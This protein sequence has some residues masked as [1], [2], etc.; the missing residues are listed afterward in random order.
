[1]TTEPLYVVIDNCLE[2]ES[3]PMPRADAGRIATEKTIAA[4]KAGEPV[5][6]GGLDRFT[7]RRSFKKVETFAV[8]VTATE[9]AALRSAVCKGAKIKA[10]P[11]MFALCEIIDSA[12]KVGPTYS[13]LEAEAALCIW[14]DMLDRRDTFYKEAF[15]PNGS[16]TMRHLSLE[17]APFVLR[18]YDRIADEVCGMW[19]YD[20]EVIPAILNT[21]TFA[22]SHTLPDETEAAAKAL[23]S[24]KKETV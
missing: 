13:A 9:R 5:S 2:T 18:V 21:I 3:E 15:T 7:V 24:L 22:A 8:I 16:V 17:L 10:Q 6:R 19:S 20:W 14:E 12:Q 11:N 23:A 4:G 1:M